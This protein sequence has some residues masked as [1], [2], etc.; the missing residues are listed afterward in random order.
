LRFEDESRIGVGTSRSRLP[1]R[2]GPAVVGHQ[3]GDDIAADGKVWRYVEAVVSLPVRLRANGPA[4]HFM[5]VDPQHVSGVRGDPRWRFG[6]H[7]IKIK[8]PSKH[9]SRE[10]VSGFSPGQE[11]IG[12]FRHAPRLVPN[13]VP[14]PPRRCATHCCLGVPIHANP[15]LKCFRWNQSIDFGRRRIP[16][17]GCRNLRLR[18]LR[19]VCAVCN[20]CR[21][22]AIYVDV[23]SVESPISRAGPSNRL[24]GRSTWRCCLRTSPRCSRDGSAAR[25][26]RS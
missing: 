7:R 16:R 18:R 1:E 15:L 13:P 10:L 17:V 21:P 23:G 9:R 25:R 20:V 8:C 12:S 4:T 3:D 2:H 14:G 6:R 19:T 11:V 24:T 5:P 22:P 26:P